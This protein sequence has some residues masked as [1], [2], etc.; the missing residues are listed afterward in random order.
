[1]ICLVD[2]EECPVVLVIAIELRKMRLF[3][4]HENFI[5]RWL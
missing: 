2:A 1:M 4:F 3:Y 5:E